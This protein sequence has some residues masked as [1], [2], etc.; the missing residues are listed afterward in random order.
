[1]GDRHLGPNAALQEAV[2]GRPRSAAWWGLYCVLC[3]KLDGFV[4]RAVNASTE[5]GM[6]LDSLADFLSFGV[7]PATLFYS[8]YSRVPGA[9]WSTGGALLGLRL[10]CVAYV[11]CAAARLARFNV[12]ADVKGADRFFFGM[13]TTFAGGMLCVK[14]GKLSRNCGLPRK[15]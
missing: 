4:A 11:V 2:A 3:D 13:P 7:V 8:F 5:F 9:G 6:Q 1:M 10:I 12:I 15:I 14:R